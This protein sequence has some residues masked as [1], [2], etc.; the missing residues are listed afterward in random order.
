MTGLPDPATSRAVLLGTASYRHLDALPSVEANLRDLAATLGDATVWGLP[1]PHCEV[2]LDPGSADA[3]LDPV[4]RAGDEATDT[5][6]VYYAGHGMRD[7][8]SADLYLGLTGSRDGVGYT[9]VAYQHLRGAIRSARARRKIIVLDCCF[10]GRAVRTLAGQGDVLAARAAVD[11]AYVLTA[12]PRDRVA[13]APDGE[14]H[15]AFTGELLG[16]LRHGLTDGPELLDLD[17]LYR[18][19]TERLGAKNRPLPQRA[20]ENGVGR[21]PLARNRALAQRRAPAGPVLDAEV[22][23]A[24]VASGL[25]LARMLRATGNSRDALPVLR[26]ALRERAPQ[27][28]GSLLPVQLELSELLAETGQI[29]EA[30]EVL[31]QAF[32]QARQVYGPEAVLVCRRLADLLQESGNHIQACE[33]LK[34]AL[35]LM[36]TGHRSRL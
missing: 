14:R 11:G 30:I 25:G 20:Q 22:R 12:S 8:E 16:I 32:H 15:T 21:L 36:E 10:S 33:V 31:E 2:V 17:T 26:L 34:H 27:D 18:A 28:A 6:V 23:A 19:L 5:L 3:M 1:E 7:T 35:D 4:H 29:K 13:L 9:A 24:M